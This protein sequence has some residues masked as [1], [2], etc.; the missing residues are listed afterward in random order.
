MGVAKRVIKRKD[1]KKSTYWYSRNRVN[2]KDKWI[3]IGKVGIITKAVAQARDEE[4]KRQIRLGQLDM[5]NADIPILSEFSKDYIQYQRDVAAKRSWERDQ[6]SLR[7]L[8]VFLGDRKLSAIT[9]K[10][11]QDYQS[12]RLKDGMRPATVNRELACLKHLFNIAKQRSNFFGDNPVSKINF[13]EENNQIE[14][15]LTH[16]EEKK[17]ISYLAP[18]IKPIISTAIYTGMRK[19]ELI[20]LKWDNVN[21][22]TNLITIE[23]TNSKSKRI[24]K[25][26]ISQTLRKVLLQQKLITGFHEFVFLTPKGDKYKRVDSLNSF[27]RACDKAGISGLRFHDLRH[28]AATRMI[29]AGVNIV[30]VSKLL[31]HAS[32]IT[33]MRYAH[34]DDSLRDAVEKLG[35]FNQ[36]CSNFR[37]NE[38]LK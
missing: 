1:G 4:I 29:E 5:I 15:V 27:K 33:T 22:D 35:N 9:P 18:H 8:N 19:G 12:R 38:K 24:K 20:S 31:G 10:D 3:S 30:V 2:G 34:P 28:T 7:H 14:R 11:I 21:L 17:L 13:L 32:I 16:D 23:A 37:S 25:I 26:P 6:L 36:N